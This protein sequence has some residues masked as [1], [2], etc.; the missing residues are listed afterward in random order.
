VLAD[1]EEL[2]TG[3]LVLERGRAR[4]RGAPA[5]LCAR[6]GESNLERAFLRCVRGD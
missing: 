2:C 5:E 3:I 6:Y 4:F 1:V